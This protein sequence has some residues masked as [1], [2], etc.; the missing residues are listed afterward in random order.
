[1][2]FIVIIIG[3]GIQ[4]ERIQARVYLIVYT[5]LLS[6]PIL[7]CVVYIASYGTNIKYVM[8]TSMSNTGYN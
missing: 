4:C 2:P 1:M 7:I 5:V 6:I 8:R 3:R